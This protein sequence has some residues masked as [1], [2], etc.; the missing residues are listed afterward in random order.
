MFK[1]G[2]LFLTESP[3]YVAKGS[4]VCVFCSDLQG[5]SGRKLCVT[6]E[7]ALLLKGDIM[8]R[9]AVHQTQHN[10]IAA[11]SSQFKPLTNTTTYYTLPLILYR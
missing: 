3:A 11:T 5:S 9:R 4:C 10:I 2:I 6:I 8:V 1:V 7:P